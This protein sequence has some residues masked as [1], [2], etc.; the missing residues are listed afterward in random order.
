FFTTRPDTIY[1]ATFMVLAPE[2][3]LVARITVAARRAEVERYVARARNMAE[4]ERTAAE[5]EKTGVDT[6]A[7]ARNVFSGEPVPIWVADYGTGSSRGSATG[8]CR[9]RWS[10][11]RPTGSCRFRTS[12]CRSSYPATWSSPAAAA[13]RSRTCRPSSTRPARSAAGPRGATPTQWT[14]SWI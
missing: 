1:G 3:P 8:E 4:I 12:S 11:A 2:H 13:R 14:R 6:G 5:R 10:T 7:F 9:F